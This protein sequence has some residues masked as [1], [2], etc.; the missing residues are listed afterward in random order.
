M[1]R[2]LHRATIWTEQGHLVVCQSLRLTLSEDI[3]HNEILKMILHPQMKTL[4]LFTQTKLIPNLFDILSFIVE[5]LIVDNQV[6][7]A[8]S[9]CKWQKKV[10]FFVYI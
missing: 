9:V 5:H 1:Y 2:K 7:S 8:T 4:S 3:Q 10:D 6:W